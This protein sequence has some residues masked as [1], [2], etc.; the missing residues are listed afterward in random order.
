[1]LFKKRCC[2]NRCGCSVGRLLIA[3]GAGLML[4]YIIPYYL[5]I[6]ILGIGLIAA[7]I[8]LSKR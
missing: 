1:M 5:L 2:R 3:I 4:A 7:G 6:I 8:W